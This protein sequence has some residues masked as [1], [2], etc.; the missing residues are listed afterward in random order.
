MMDEGFWVNPRTLWRTLR[1]WGVEKRN[2]HP[3]RQQV[4]WVTRQMVEAV[5]EQQLLRENGIRQFRRRT[6]EGFPLL[7]ST[8]IAILTGISRWWFRQQR[9]FPRRALTL[10]EWTKVLPPILE[11]HR[12]GHHALVKLTHLRSEVILRAGQ[13]VAALQTHGARVITPAEGHASAGT[14][15][16]RRHLDLSLRR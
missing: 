1:Q 6:K 8:S 3:F 10:E 16:H 13:I 4:V 2:R 7:S 5:V 12:K 14:D 11:R 9:D 15:V